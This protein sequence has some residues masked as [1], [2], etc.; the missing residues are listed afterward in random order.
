MWFNESVP[1]YYEK[2][3]NFVPSAFDT[4]PNALSDTG[5]FVAYS[6]KNTGYHDF[7]I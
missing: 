7:L 4:K 3:I 5:A 6:G 1:E 2:G